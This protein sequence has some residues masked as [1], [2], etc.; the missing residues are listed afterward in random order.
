MKK[1]EF[2]SPEVI[3]YGKDILLDSGEKIKSFGQKALLVT[4]QMMTKLGYTKKTTDIL[5]ANGIEYCIYDEVDDEPID[6]MVEKGAKI[7]KDND[8]EFLITLGGGSPIDAAKAIGI[9]ATNQ[10]KI[11]DFMGQNKVQNAIPPLIA[12]P[13]TAGTG[14][15]ATK[16]TIITD[17]EN[18]VKML[19]GSP[20]LLPD[21]AIVDCCLTLSVPPDLTAATGIDALTH[22]IEAYTS[23]K[24]Q[25][26]SDQFAL[27]AI[28]RISNNLKTA[29]FDGNDKYARNEMM[30]A[31]LEAGIAFSNS[32]VTLVHGMSRPIGAVFHIPHG[33]SN[34]VLLPT[35]ME[36]AVEGAPERFAQVAK[37]MGIEGDYEELE[38]AKEGAK[39][40]KKLCEDIKVPNVTELGIDEDEF[41]KYTDKMAED[42]LASGSPGNTYR[43][44]SKEDII[45]I[46][47]EI[48]NN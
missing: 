28:R 39:K 48:I 16:F 8:C 46:Y 4:D 31:S 37:A 20:L 2:L 12:I 7:Y 13:T 45:K 35:C 17:T 38:L 15:E 36:Y 3:V 5:E 11:S 43:A 29:C 23:I 30:L 41:L 27:S 34:A 32:S 14:S 21:M 18:D 47:E 44:P 26:L 6:L 24:S 1:H 25:P 22:A 10:G 9:L 40:V 19:I 33:I 42:A